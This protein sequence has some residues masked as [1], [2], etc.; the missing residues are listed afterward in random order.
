[1]KNKLIL[2]AL[3]IFTFWFT[4]TY[5]EYE[6]EYYNES[7]DAFINSPSAFQLEEIK[8]KNTRYCEQ[9]YLEATRRREYTE[10]E[11]E[12]CSEL[13]SIKRQQELD[14][15]NYVFWNRGIFY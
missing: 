7:V 14:Y 8:D 9:V 5:S 11:L 2:I 6:N 3:L 1:V 10:E 12:L 4:N 13:F 15:M